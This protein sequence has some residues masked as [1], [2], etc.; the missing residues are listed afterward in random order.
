MYE[1]FSKQVTLSREKSDYAQEMELS[2]LIL[3]SVKGFV[4]TFGTSMT[5]GIVVGMGSA[6]D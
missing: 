1:M 3:E 5:I 2:D 4:L 6:A